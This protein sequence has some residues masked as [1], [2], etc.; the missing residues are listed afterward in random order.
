MKKNR[1]GFDPLTEKN[2]NDAKHVEKQIVNLF[3]RHTDM[4]LELN[5]SIFSEK[6][7]GELNFDIFVSVISAS[8]GT[9]Y[10]WASSI[11][12]KEYADKVLEVGIIFAKKNID[13]SMP[14][15]DV[16]DESNEEKVLVEGK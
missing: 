6:N 13:F 1:F 5:K 10:L 11:C 3:D 2:K 8:I 14:K 4:L 15:S 12:G 16:N 7:S 9:A